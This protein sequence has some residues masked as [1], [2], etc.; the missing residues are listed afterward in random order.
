MGKTSWAWK[1][2]CWLIAACAALAF[3]SGLTAVAVVLGAFAILLFF[4]DFRVSMSESVADSTLGRIARQEGGLTIRGTV[5]LALAAALLVAAQFV[6]LLASRAA[7][8]DHVSALC[9]ICLK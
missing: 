9:L 3:Y 4:V 2:L 8:T 7:P 1:L 5:Y 6:M